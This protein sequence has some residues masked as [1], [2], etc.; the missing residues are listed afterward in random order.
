MTAAATSDLPPIFVISLARAAA[1]RENMR[2]RLDALG[3]RYEIVNAV[4]GKELDLSQYGDRL[5]PDLW[6]KTARREP[7]RGEIG[8]FL[9]HYQLWER[10][11]DTEHDC[12]LILE[13]DAVWGDDFADI[14][15][16]VVNC[17]WEWDVVLFSHF[18]AHPHDFAL[19]ELGGG[20]KLVRHRRPAV[21]AAAY[22]IRPSA[23]RKLCQHCHIIREAVDVLYVQY[24]RHGA[25]FYHVDPPPVWQDETPSLL[26]DG[27]KI[28]L[29][30][31]DW[32]SRKWSRMSERWVCRFYRW[33]HRP[34][35]R[36]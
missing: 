29:T 23:A 30:P 2:R 5:R 14:V 1:R 25:A 16:R 11:A 31:G 27:E 3:A 33:T 35:K 9:S 13:D 8:C 28:K 20:R 22:L 24:W 21:T 7:T 19:C 26:Q 17:A 12:A 15:G 32:L 10:I 34:Q 4:D 18:R 36:K 6:R